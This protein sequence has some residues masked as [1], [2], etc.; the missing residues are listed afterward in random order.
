MYI[1]PIGSPLSLASLPIFV[2][3]GQQP[4]QQLFMERPH[5]WF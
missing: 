1:F 5:L 2:T 3:K 4:A